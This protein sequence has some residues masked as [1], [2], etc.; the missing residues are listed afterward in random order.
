MVVAEIEPAYLLTTTFPSFM[1]LRFG[2][3]SMMHVSFQSLA[4][5]VGKRT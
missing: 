4:F 3:F 2:H 1:T 5:I